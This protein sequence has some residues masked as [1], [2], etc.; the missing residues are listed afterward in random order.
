M[1]GDLLKGFHFCP[2]SQGSVVCSLSPI[3][4]ADA[5]LF[6]ESRQAVFSPRLNKTVIQIHDFLHTDQYSPGLSR[7]SVHSCSAI[8]F[9]HPDQVN[10]LQTLGVDL[11]TKKI[12]VKPIGSPSWFKPIFTH[13]PTRKIGWVGRPRIHAGHDLKR[14]DWLLTIAESSSFPVEFC[15]YGCGLGSLFDCLKKQGSVASYV[16]KDQYNYST[17]PVFY[18]LLNCLLITS[19]SE[20]GPLPLFEALSCGIPVISTRVGWAPLLIR[21]GFN[22]FL[23]DSLEEMV[24]R[25]NEFFK[26]EKNWLSRKNEI[27]E[28]SHAFTLENWFYSNLQF[29]LEVSK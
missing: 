2:F 26:N 1:F 17:L 24:E 29:A 20:A 11:S 27:A 9:T 19:V 14:S 22:G 23:V 5:F 12:L 10:L 25:V 6:F 13:T 8:S 28:K 7:S 18:S 4:R 3:P 16:Q 15:L 21:D